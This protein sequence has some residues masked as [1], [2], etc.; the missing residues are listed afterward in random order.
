MG[1]KQ[2]LKKLRDQHRQFFLV[3]YSETDADVGRYHCGGGL[4]LGLNENGMEEARKLSRRFKKNPLK[5]KRIYAS[6]ELRSVQMADFLHDELKGKLVLSR[7]FAD[8]NLGS[9]EGEPLGSDLTA[10]SV[11]LEPKRGETETAFSLRVREGLEAFL[12]EELL[13]VLV[14]HPRVAMKILS[15]LGL[16]GEVIERGKMYVLDLP[17]DQGAAHLREV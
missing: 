4:D 2:D 17:V 3:V 12:H 9:S 14:T 13:S 5:I 1:S 15:W 11:L 10:T 8:Q 7:N 6:P 16:T